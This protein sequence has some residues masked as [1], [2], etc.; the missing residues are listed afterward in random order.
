MVDNKNNPESDLLLRRIRKKHL[1]LGDTSV[2]RHKRHPEMIKR[3]WEQKKTWN[4]VFEKEIE[5]RDGYI[6]LRHAN[7]FGVRYVHV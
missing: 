5:D 2:D 6:P 4:E 3:T 7:Y 1:L